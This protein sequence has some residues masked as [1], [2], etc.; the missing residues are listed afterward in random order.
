MSRECASDDS[1]LD[2]PRT[3]SGTINAYGSGHIFQGNHN[4]GQINDM[5]QFYT[6]KIPGYDLRPEVKEHY[7][8]LTVGAGQNP[9]TP[10]KQ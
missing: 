1:Q 8:M 9:R 3:Y 6:G 2:G 10:S 7:C 5:R 4:V